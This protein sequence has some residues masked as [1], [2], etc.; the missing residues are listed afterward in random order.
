MTSQPPSPTRLSRRGFLGATFAAGVLLL[1]EPE[2]AT[3]AAV[4][5]DVTLSA[6]GISVLA[7]VGGRVAI[8]DGSGATRLAGSKFQ[9]KDTVTGIQVSTGG[10][11]TLVTLED[12][13]PAIRMD[14]LMPAAAGSIVVYGLFVVRARQV[15]L[16]WHV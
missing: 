13:T 5:G 14:Y 12:G 8:R 9:I 4:D 10:T 3:A 7:S 15:H 11:P 1:S 16:E 2:T 6:S